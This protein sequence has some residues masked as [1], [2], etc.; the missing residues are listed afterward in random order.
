MTITADALA[1][2]EKPLRDY[3]MQVVF[4]SRHRD[5]E[6]STLLFQ[7]LRGAGA[8]VGWNASIDDIEDKDRLPLLAL[9]RMDRR[10]N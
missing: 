2:H 5:V 10:Q 7:F 8:K 1:V 9:R 3:Q 6:Q 4:R